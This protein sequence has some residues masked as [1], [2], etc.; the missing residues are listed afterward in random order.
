MNKIN[1]Y[2]IDDHKMFRDGV[3]TFLSTDQFNIIGEAGNGKQ[4]I[5][6]I[7]EDTDIVL[8]DISMPELD[9][10][11]ATKL[12]VEKNPAIKIIA[13]S[14]YGD[15]EYYYKMIHSGAKG[16]VLKEAG[17]DELNEAIIQ[18]YNGNHFFSQEL[19]KN[20]II[21]L[22]TK[23]DN[24]TDISFSDREIE[25]LQ[26]VCK[27]FSSKEIGEALHIS[28]RTVESHKAKLLQKTDSKNTIQLVM[29]SIKNKLVEIH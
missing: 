21:S 28:Q 29:Y 20:V 8:M 6:E 24:E 16:Y 10:I 18:V 12:L 15:E 17:C 19:L 14:M 23:S 4:G 26:K 13:L 5:E 22:S 2:I 25:I 11:Q 9:G 7:P 1:I 27:G 3:K